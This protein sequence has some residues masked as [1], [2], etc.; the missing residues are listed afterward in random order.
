MWDVTWRERDVSLR[1]DLLHGLDLHHRL[2]GAPAWGDGL[3]AARP[4]GLDPRGL[5]AHDAGAGATTTGAGSTHDRARARGA[6]RPRSPRTDRRS[7]SRR[8]ART[9][10]LPAL[11][12]HHEFGRRAAREQQRRGNARRTIC[13][14]SRRLDELE[15]QHQQREHQE[16]V[17]ER[18]RPRRRPTSAGTCRA[19]CPQS[20]GMRNAIM[21]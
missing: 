19:W 6:A 14:A 4:D 8:T 15:H 21:L 10:E 17:A 7:R 18:R 16:R 3:R 13:R 20:I 2:G 9:V 11:S 12:H 1:L 5:G